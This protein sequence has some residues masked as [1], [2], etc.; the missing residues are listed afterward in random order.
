MPGSARDSQPRPVSGRSECE[1]HSRSGA[2]RYRDRGLLDGPGGCTAHV[3][4][5]GVDPVGLARRAAL[6]AGQTERSSA[7]RLCR[8]RPCHDLQLGI[9]PGVPGPG[10]RGHDQGCLRPSTGSCSET[11]VAAACI[12]APASDI[13]FCRRSFGFV[14]GRDGGVGHFPSRRLTGSRS[15]T[16]RVESVC[17]SSACSRCA[18]GA[19][20][21]GFGGF[22]Q[23]ETWLWL[24]PV[25]GV[26]FQSAHRSRRLIPAS[27][28][29][30]SSSDG[31]T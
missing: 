28:A 16:P 7:H 29:M 25:N 1:V 18:G 8:R 17:S 14:G 12:A 22:S 2:V 6:P 21:H 5:V 24:S 9:D 19:N 11:T 27:R 20:D 23:T 10:T 3:V 26:R 15:A 4:A 31:H 13:R 30:R